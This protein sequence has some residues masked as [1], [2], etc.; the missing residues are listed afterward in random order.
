MNMPQRQRQVN[1]AQRP[2]MTAVLRK[3]PHR[4]RESLRGLTKR[5]KFGPE[6]KFSRE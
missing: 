4:H 3:F 6:H 2:A 1:A 5:R